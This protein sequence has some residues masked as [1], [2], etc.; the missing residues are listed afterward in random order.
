MLSHKLLESDCLWLIVV[1]CWDAKEF[2]GGVW[3]FRPELELGEDFAAAGG[4]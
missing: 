2:I 4:D 1:G 3:E